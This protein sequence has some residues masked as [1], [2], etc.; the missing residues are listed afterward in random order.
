M[1]KM[2]NILVCLLIFF[3]LLA[4]LMYLKIENKKLS[5]LKVILVQKEMRALLIERQNIVR[6]VPADGLWYN[7][8][9]SRETPGILEV[10]IKDQNNRPICNLKMKISE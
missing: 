3:I 9:R 6:S 2:K 1:N 10:Q 4:G 5:Q 7:M 8:R